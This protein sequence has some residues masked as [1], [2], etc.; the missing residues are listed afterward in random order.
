MVSLRIYVKI[1]TYKINQYSL[2]NEKS[3]LWSAQDR[4]A[5][6]VNSVNLVIL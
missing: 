6:F 2:N 4:I 5:T 3:E 1:M